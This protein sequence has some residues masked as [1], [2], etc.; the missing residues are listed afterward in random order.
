MP[1]PGEIARSLRGK[2]PAQRARAKAQAYT[3]LDIEGHVFTNGAGYTMALK[4]PIQF[5]DTP[6]GAGMIGLRLRH[7][8][9]PA[10]VNLPIDDWYWFINPPISV[11]GAEESSLLPVLEQ[12]V[13]DA[14][15]GYAQGKGRE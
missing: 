5:Q 12:M 7:F 4:G 3:A 2:T 6:S 8:I 13:F 9:S 10:G 1:T 11:S 14:A 15:L